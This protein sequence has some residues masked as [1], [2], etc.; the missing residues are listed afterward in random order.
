MKFL[1]VL[2]RAGVDQE[3]C[4]ILIAGK[5]DL[6]NLPPIRNNSTKPEN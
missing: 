3:I 5:R 1:L 6:C 4:E 2:R